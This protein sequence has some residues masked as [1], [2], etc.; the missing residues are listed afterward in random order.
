MRDALGELVDRG[1]AHYDHIWRDFSREARLS[2]AALADLQDRLGDVTEAAISSRLGSYQI[3]L[4]PGQVAIAMEQLSA[5]DIV[6]VVSRVR[7]SY[8]F[9]AQMYG[10]WLR[11]CKL[12]G[13]VVEEV[14]SEP[15]AK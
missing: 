5:R 15:I 1:R 12:L 4:D 3:R 11:R 13:K 2:L 9:T 7:M 6:Q 14:G 10:H 8:G